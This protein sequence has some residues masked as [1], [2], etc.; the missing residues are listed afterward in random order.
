MLS[1]YLKR[2]FLQTEWNETFL[3]FLLQIGEI[4]SKSDHSVPTHVDYIH[5]NALLGYSEDLLFDIIWKTKH[6]MEKR[7]I[8][9]I[10]VI[11]KS[12]RIQ[13]DFCIMHYEM[14]GKQDPIANT[15]S[16]NQGKCFFK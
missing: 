16:K 15:P 9:A 12:F 14:S 13:N 2:I 6:S 7:N 5:T 11:N 8:L 1:M 4:H 10:K 3:Q